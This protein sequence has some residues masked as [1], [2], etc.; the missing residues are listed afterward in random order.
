MELGEGGSVYAQEQS[1]WVTGERAEINGREVSG[2][3]Y[4][5]GGDNGIPF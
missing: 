3:P 2:L 1:L 4:L 5:F